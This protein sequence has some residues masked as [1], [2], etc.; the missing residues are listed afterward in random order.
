R[1][2]FTYYED[3]GDDTVYWQ[4]HYLPHI[5]IGYRCQKT[6]GIVTYRTGL[7]FPELEYLGFGLAL[8]D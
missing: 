5:N 1:L 8:K 2:L 7:R 4:T 6:G 3:D